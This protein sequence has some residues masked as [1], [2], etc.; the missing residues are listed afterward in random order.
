[1][2]GHHVHKEQAHTLADALHFVTRFIT[3]PGAVGSLWPSSRDL[4]LAMVRELRLEAGDV[5]VEYGPGTGPFTSVLR[6]WMPPGTEYL[7]I[8]FDPE[9]HRTL[10]R[11]FPG[12][13][14]HLGS[15]ED[16]P[17]ILADHG[18]GKARI[19]ISGLPFSIMPPELQHRILEAT[20][21]A[22]HDEGTFRTFT[23]LFSFLSP[24]SNHFH[25]ML[26]RHFREHHTAR[27][28]GEKLPSGKGPQLL[29]TGEDKVGDW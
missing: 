20:S 29:G 9:L 16:T 12:M 28:G 10:V 26:S 1:M 22:L 18:L 19:I 13:R 27:N 5:L 25:R 11:R 23:Y 14:F 17:A 15:A 7:G 4:G 3:K 8:E 21:A 24:G 2:S 6:E